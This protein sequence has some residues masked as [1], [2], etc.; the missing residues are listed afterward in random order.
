MTDPST[1]EE[2]HHGRPWW[3]WL[4]WTLV[5]LL[6]LPVMAVLLLQLEP[7]QDYVRRQGEQYLQKKLQTKVRIGY[8]RMRGW[9]YLELR[10]VYV[11][12]RASKTLLFSSSLKVRYNLLAF[13]NNELRVNGLEWDSVLINLYRNPGDSVFNYQFIQD[14]FVTKDAVP[15]TI[16][17][18]T[19]TTIQLRIKDVTLRKARLRFM[20]AQGGMT[21]IV[22]FQELHIDPDDLL[23]DEG[24]YAFRGIELNGM[25]GL[26]TQAYR[27]KALTNAA[28]P[29]P[30]PVDTAGTPF[31]LLLK[32]L[33][34]KNSAFLYSDEASGLSTVW[35]ISNLQLLN[36][37]IDLDSTL[38][39]IGD[40]QIDKTAGVFTL[41]AAR[42]TSAPVPS[43]SE[44]NTWK[45]VATK[46]ELEQVDFK[47]DNNIAPPPRGA[48][49]DPDYNHLFLYNF[50][51]S[52]SNI[53]YQ[54]DTISAVLKRLEVR[55]KSGFAVKQARFNV[56][57]TSQT[58]ALENMLLETNKSLLR[59]QI[60]VS[61]PS[62]STLS[63]NMDLLQLRANIDSSH[64]TLGEWLPFVPDSRKNPSMKP[65]WDKVVDITAVLKGS[66]GK[67]IIETL[68]IT[69][70]VGNRIH[71]NGVIEHTTNADRFYAN[72]P[73][74]Y[75]QS[76]N[77][78][79]RSWLPAGTLPD[80]PRLPE[81][82]LITGNILGGMQ[83]LKTQLQLTSS[84]ANAQLSA[85]LVNITDSIRAR[86]DVNVASFKVHPGILLYDTTMGW[87]S[88]RMSASGQGYT[89]PG[90]VAKAAID[91]DAATYNRYTYHG[92]TMMGNID[93]Q[94][95]HAE[96][97]STDTSITLT[98]D[99][100]ALLGDTSVQSLQ[101]NLQMDKADLYVTNWYSE[102]MILK[103]N[104]AA[105]FSSLEPQR[106]VGTAFLHNWQVATNG[107]VFP[108]DTIAFTAKYED[109]QYISLD[110]PF[111]FIHANGK[112]DY[113]KVG[114]A[115]GQLINKPLQ[116]YDS[117]RLVQLP[118]GQLLHWNASLS[119]PRN[120]KNMAPGLRME[121]PLLIDGRLNTD[122]SLL[123]LNANLLK[124]TYD[125][126]RVDSVKLA[127]QI[128]DTALNAALDLARL[129][130][131]IL[132][133]QH[134]RLTAR[135]AGGKLEWDLLADDF[136][137]KPKYKVG[138][139][140][141]FLPANA[142]D[143]SLK[144]DLLLNKQQWKVDEN[145]RIHLING[146]PDTAHLTLSYQ[147]QSIKIETLRDSSQ[148]TLPPLKTTIKD[149]KLSTIT[150][151]LSS[152]TLLANGILNAEALI[153][154]MDKSPMVNS[155]LRVDSFAFRGT[156]V[157]TLEAKVETPQPNQ[158]KLAANLTGN[159]NDVKVEGT[160][161]TTI[162]AQVDINNINMAS[163]EAFTFGNVTRMHG[164]ADGQFSITGT[165]DKPK[166]LGSLHFNDAG[167]T[168]TYVGAHLRLPDETINIDERGI[169]FNQFVVADSLDNELVVDGRINTRDFNR[170][171][172]N[173]DINSENFM[174]LGEQ[175][176]PKQLYYGP[177]FIDTRIRVRG[178]LDL[179]RIDANVKLRD[180]SNITITLPSEEPGIANREGV[181][182]FVDKSNPL[183]SS[184]FK[185]IDS[186]RFE[187]PRLKGINLSG[188]AEITPESIIKIII[189]PV[190]G[191]F[192]QA[193]GT[194]NINAT[195][196]ASS[197]MSLTGRYEISEGKYE[198]SLNQLIKRSFSIEK[199]STI[200]FSGEAMEAD[201]NIT[202]RY[203]VNATA[204]DL[205]QDQLT[206][207][208]EIDR[209]RYRQKLPFYVY[210]RI[211]GQMMKPEISF[212]LD[213]PE[214]EQ[215]AF[216]GSVYNRLKQINQIPSELNKQVMGLLVLN[217]FIPE[218][219]LASDGG[220]SG[221]FGARNMARQSVSKILSQQLNNL[222]GNLIKGVDLNFDVESRQDYS[223]GAEQETTNL[224]VGASKKLF[225]ERL[226]VSVGS[227]V[228]L[229]GENQA[230]PSS[231]VGDISVEYK[232]TK[233]GRYR[234]K[235]YQR[236]DNS[237]VIEGQVVET[238]VAFALIMDY[239]EFREI[240]QRVKSQEKKEKLRK[241]KTVSKK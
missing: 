171:N 67:L 183:D 64:I 48:G 45:V 197:K 68:R 27:P 9:Q 186:T 65:L 7:V 240:F 52:I 61:V 187:N 49:K 91:L 202:A 175:Q 230:N 193:Q 60:A 236:N 237:T 114:G 162:N 212:E 56:L 150:G 191:D 55:E 92:I 219:P 154:N 142:M 2:K 231:L 140:V 78:P 28:P 134:T 192:V 138:G 137:R 213:M 151:L 152:D 93:K 38:V 169:E 86:Y 81:Q 174:I 172:F 85:H 121:Q 14:A 79:L 102:P 41:S 75:I 57:F 144:N 147:N 17:E 32:K 110:G 76:G 131:Q 139:Y 106:L 205:V 89:F 217:S 190:N 71:A 11:A 200:T 160:Y 233:D 210:L 100:N 168:I 3:R 198:M 125:S 88:G 201:L 50:N 84:S 44:P 159:Q 216:N 129:Y 229:Q 235:V 31:H 178:N 40:L 111:G 39:Q 214:A 12:D 189:D 123:V 16:S 163:L 25:K 135:A 24:V 77:K 117:S 51:T 136:R 221:D 8:L 167:G 188:N 227:N 173:L 194:A 196:D 157:G 148:G 222:A 195:L 5:V 207:M 83:D 224:K 225:N 69:D 119:W 15:D 20:D 82:M 103:G 53:L 126:L 26:Y 180:K 54:A 181:I 72:L 59:K 94:Q 215:N 164:S 165:T 232:L 108:L 96:G 241:K 182:V 80:T 211:K 184:L 33:H 116:P 153:S 204:A 43:E 223:T 145:N 239:D 58:L 132:P 203:T 6:I 133:L 179:P 99:V 10:N 209:N 23:L 70:N 98:F 73:S 21:A 158:Y 36:S 127:V 161:D 177:A 234:V 13:L 104:L 109:Q 95:L 218:D 228:M 46:A 156:P 34:I 206:N 66:L 47:F 113:T 97:L 149:F 170:Y 118:A 238:G 141:T 74:V 29:P 105:D 107:Q 101:A 166:I 4:L 208:S 87:I 90:M 22:L 30:I 176:D 130:H 122:S 42:D 120:L 112:I 199:G 220:G 226:S 146:G 115:F 19:G 124:L 185:A 35:R 1:K 63:E 128:Q 62:W 143:I 18:E 155:S 37:N